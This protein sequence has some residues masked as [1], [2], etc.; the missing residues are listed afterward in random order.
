MIGLGN[1]FLSDDSVGLKVAH[2]VS[3]RL[4]ASIDAETAILHTGGVSLM[5][6]MAGFDRAVIVDAA[7]SG[8]AEPGS[9]HR[10]YGADLPVT[11]NTHS[12]HDGSLSIAL[13]LGRIA[14]LRLPAEVRVWA[15]EAGDVNTFNEQL[16]E[17]VASAL[18]RVVD[19]IVETLR[20]E[21]L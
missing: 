14:G 13:E 11:R 12:S 19:E 9:I 1:P 10:F 16:T 6:A 3:G 8:Q 17:P 5:E 2:A 7:V 4:D 21:R 18:P 20:G 15:I